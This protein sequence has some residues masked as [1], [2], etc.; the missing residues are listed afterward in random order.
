MKTAGRLIAASFS[1]PCHFIL[2]S[3][4]AGETELICVTETSAS[5]RL[6]PQFGQQKPPR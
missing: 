5:C 4:P 6:Y 3:E 2:T 1:L